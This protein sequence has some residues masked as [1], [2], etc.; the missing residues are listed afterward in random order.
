MTFEAYPISFQ[1]TR[2]WNAGVGS[3]PF[4]SISVGV[5]IGIIIITITTKTRFQRALKKEGHVVPEERLVPMCIGAV[6]LPIGMF[7]FG[8][9]S[10]TTAGNV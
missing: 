10:I 6:I 2:G 1:Q 7:W 4:I 8:S 3:L 9:V 5:V